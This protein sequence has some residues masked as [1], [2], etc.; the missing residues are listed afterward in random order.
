MSRVGKMP[1]P[2]PSG[3]N[4]TVD[5]AEITVAG[6]KGTLEHQVI[7]RVGEE[8]SPAKID[9]GFLSQSTKGVQEPGNLCW[10]VTR[11]Q[12]RA[13]QHVVIL[14]AQRGRNGDS[15]FTQRLAVQN[16]VRGSE[17]RAQPGNQDVGIEDDEH[18]LESTVAAAQ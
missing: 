2:I 1:I 14:Q 12:A 4:V 10:R 15:V 11:E 16:S 7:L 3:V 17:R 5:D 18:G 8:R 9:K 6:G 13:V